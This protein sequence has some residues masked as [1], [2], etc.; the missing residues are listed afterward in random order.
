MEKEKSV[1]HKLNRIDTSKETENINGKTPYLP[2][3]KAWEIVK[4]EYPDAYYRV[5]EYDS[6]PYIYDENL[7]Y[8]VHTAV[9]IDGE[10]LEEYLP[11]MDS[12]HRARKSHPYTIK[13]S[14]SEVVVEPATARDISDAIHR[15]LVK[16][17]ALFGLG[18]NLWYKE[19]MSEAAREEQEL[20]AWEE[21]EKTSIGWIEQMN[22][23]EELNN[24]AS[25]LGQNA[26]RP[27]IK[28]AL[29]RRR[30]ELAK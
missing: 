28:E 7:G 23:A 1:F 29:I 15:C 26:T 16:N 11:V 20:K 5:V 8:L 19:D 3:A 22:T 4:R 25:Q 24:Y 17:L 27:A 2:W 18:I 6:K 14:K 30:K 10:T 12:S 21:F 9:S 13:Y